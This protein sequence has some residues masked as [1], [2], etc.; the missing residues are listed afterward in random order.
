M[1][2][3]KPQKLVYD[4]E[5][6]SGGSIA[7]VC[8]SI[9][10]NGQKEVEILQKAANDIVKLND[11]L[12]IRTS[13]TETGTE[14]YETEFKYETFPVLTFETKEELTEYAT[15]FANEP[16]DFYGS[17]CH[18]SIIM[19]KDFYGIL[20][21]LH[22]IISDAWTLSLIGNQFNALLNG[23][24]PEAYSYFDYAISENE[25]IAGKRY[26]KDKVYFIDNF[27][28]CD[29]VTYLSDKQ[30]KSAN[31]NRKTFVVDK[32]TTSKILRYAESQN[33]SVFMVLMTA[34]AVYINRVKMNKEK[35]YIGTAVLNRSNIQEK[36]TMGMFINTIPMLIELDNDKTFEENLENISN[37]GYAV[38]RHQKY[39][40]GDILKDLRQEFSFTEKLYDV[41]FSYQNASIEGES[42]ETAWY[43]PGMQTESLQIHVDDRDN[44]GILN[45]HYDYQVEK[46][47]EKE[48][49]RMH[50]H[51]FNLLLDAMSW[52]N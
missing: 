5:K 25:Y 12:R 20:V 48:I 6:F 11:A 43:S 45:M 1:K 18:I 41:I 7:T 19:S 15:K 22:H 42:F 31:T 33:T 49:E 2:L 9:V 50:N 21:K 8:G 36:N 44:E 17:L 28:K 34:L 52:F 16:M 4:M 30:S 3:T 23:E 26:Q 39:N 37:E 27:K 13:E 10:Y 47:T 51:I 35:F 46:F 29:E 32:N 24:K 40:Y 14:Q 38:L